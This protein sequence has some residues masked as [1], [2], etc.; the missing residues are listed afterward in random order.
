[1]FIFIVPLRSPE[2]CSNWREVSSLCNSTL[3]SLMQ[4]DSKNYQVILVCNSPP[5]DFIP[6]EHITLV[7]ESFSIPKSWDEANADIYTKVKRGMLE[8][9]N[10]QLIRPDSSVFVMRVDADDLVSNRLVSFAERFQ[11][12]DGWY[13]AIGYIY[14]IGKNHMFIRPR[15]NAVSGTSHIIKCTYSDFPKSMETPP[16]EWLDVIWQHLRVNELLKP[17]SRKLTFLPFPGAVYRINPQNLSSTNLEDKRFSS[18]KSV[19]WKI[20]CKRKLTTKIIN[21]FKLPTL[22]QS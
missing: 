17:K 22:K 18:L 19:L 11:N 1:M 3:K 14:E 7:Q 16:T 5:L 2:T 13:F 20:L 12:S 4:Q 21:E 9:K 10:L 15:F 8:V 6:N